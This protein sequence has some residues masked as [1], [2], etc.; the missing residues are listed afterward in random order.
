MT[1]SSTI[2]KFLSAVLL[3]LGQLLLLS[4]SND[5]SDPTTPTTPEDGTGQIEVTTLVES[6][7]A[8]D[9]L[10]V[11]KNGNIYA[12][13]FGGWSATGGSGSEILKITPEG[14]VTTFASGLSGP[15]GITITESGNFYVVNDN[16]GTSGDIVQIMSDGTLS[17]LATIPG[18]PAGI[19][20]DAGGNLYIS[21]YK[22][23]TLH[24]L[25]TDGVLT[26][27]ANDSQ[28]QGCVGIDM[29]EK[30]DIYTANYNN[31][32][33]LKVTSDGTVSLVTT[34]TG[35]AANF[36][37]GYIAYFDGS[38]YA[39]GIGTNKIY[40]V[41][42]DGSQ[43]T[44]AGSGQDAHLD[45]PLLSAGFKNPNGIAFDTTNKIM[46]VLDWGKPS[47]RKVELE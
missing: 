11:D 47:L 24:K 15:L 18:W 9:A 14:V 2:R 6:I 32:K 10:V 16:D 26:Q 46:Y 7:G 22:E 42:L 38:L 36:G 28:L 13:N 23:S 30:G 17:E 4:C 41:E 43:K 33:V 20:S 37:I 25:S 35:V 5:E 21:N 40:Q 3:C 8:N 1:N 19:I 45:G 29:D 31:G 44:F 34:I 27:L 39:T 12:A